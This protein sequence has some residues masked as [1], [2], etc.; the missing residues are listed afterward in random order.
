MTQ[1]RFRY[2]F[3]RTILQLVL[4]AVASSGLAAQ[5]PGPVANLEL[6][7]SNEGSAVVDVRWDA[8]ATPVDHFTVFTGYGSEGHV[9]FHSVCRATRHRFPI[10][11]A[12][13]YTVMVVAQRGELVGTPMTASIDISRDDMDYPANGQQI[14]FLSPAPQKAI[15]QQPFEFT[16]QAREAYDQPLRFSLVDKPYGM[17]IDAETGV[18]AWTPMS[19]GVAQATVRASVAND[20][21]IEAFQS[22]QIEVIAAEDNPLEAC[23]RVVAVVTT[24][25]GYELYKGKVTAVRTDRQVSAREDYSVRAGDVVCERIEQGVATLDLAA[26][27]YIFKAEGSSI[28]TTW[29][30]DVEDPRDAV[31]INLRCGQQSGSGKVINIQAAPRKGSGRRTVVSGRVL[32][33]STNKGIRSLVVFQP[34]P[35]HPVPD[36]FGASDVYAAFTEN[37]GTF[38][39]S[40][41]DDVVYVAEAVSLQVDPQT[42]LPAHANRFNGAANSPLEA[43]LIHPAQSEGEL[44]FRLRTLPQPGNSISFEVR[45]PIESLSLGGAAVF[46]RLDRTT[47]PWTV[48]TWRPESASAG[49]TLTAH[50]LEAGDYVVQFVPWSAAYPVYYRGP[51]GPVIDIRDAQIFSIDDNYDKSFEFVT[52]A[53]APWQGVLDTRGSVLHVLP[54]TSQT[55]YAHGALTYAFDEAGKMIDYAVVDEQGEFALDRLG[56]GNYRIVVSR[57]V[58]HTEYSAV[59]RSYEIF[60][61]ELPTIALDCEVQATAVDDNQTMNAATGLRLY[62]QPADDLLHIETGDLLR[63]V[64]TLRVYDLTGLL[65]IERSVAGAVGTDLELNTV[66]LAGGIYILQLEGV[67]R[68]ERRMFVVNK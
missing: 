24:E 42:E 53:L 59:P 15:V 19:P 60:T 14:H 62:P 46:Q 1:A 36:L 25:E 63:H 45:D 10:E 9:R 32:S 2:I 40:L 51:F 64:L 61:L 66:N 55:E 50:N 6:H 52:R 41:F 4:L 7:F 44:H 57:D 65:L 8:P 67:E 54:G 27:D 56:L 29:N 12:G 34:A 20:P 26:G 43:P 37:D 28:N 48:E 30:G 16:V 23:I 3:S 13:R 17:Y 21:Q 35:G 39:A 58:C 5:E 47:T 49:R 11:M 38:S 18:V 33:E 22:W 31:P 68:T